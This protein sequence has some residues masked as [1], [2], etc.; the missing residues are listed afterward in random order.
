MGCENANPHFQRW[1]WRLG[2][3]REEEKVKEPKTGVGNRISYDSLSAFLPSSSSHL[4]SVEFF[5]LF[6]VDFCDNST[7]AGCDLWLRYAFT[8]LH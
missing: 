7:A 3:G 5:E 8:L 1:P 4:L 6:F 2:R